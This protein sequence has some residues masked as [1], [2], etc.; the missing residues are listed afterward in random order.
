MKKRIA[1]ILLG[2][3]LIGQSFM[4]TG[5][6]DEDSSAA[7]ESSTESTESRSADS[8]SQP[9]NSSESDSSKGDARPKLSLEEKIK[10]Y[11]INSKKFDLRNVNGI[12]YVTPVRSQAPFGTCW[13]FATVAAIESS[14]LGAGLNG[15]DGKPA[16]PKTLDLSEKQIAWFSA[17]ALNDPENSQNGE[18]QYVADFMNNVSVLTEFMNRG[19]N[20]IFST[21][22]LAQGIGP[23][24]ES[25]DPNLE[26]H[27]KDKVIDYRGIGDSIKPLAYSAFDDWT[28][29][30]ECRFISSYSVKETH[31]LPSPSER[32]DDG[33]YK[34][35]AEAT[36][37]IKEELLALRGVQISFMA[38][39]SMPD[40]NNSNT[41]FI[42]NNWAHYTYLPTGTNHAVTIVGWDDDYSKEN[43]IKGTE[44]VEMIDGSKKTFDKTPPENGAWLV[45]NS[46]GSGENDF[47]DNNGGEWGIEENGKHTG[48]FWLSYYDQSLLYP[49]S[50][51]VEE[52]DASVDCT[53][54]YD[55]LPTGM[56]DAGRFKDEHKM[57]N[58]FYL[59]HNETLRQVSFFTAEPDTEV[60]YEI[61]LM[62]SFS[63]NPVKG[64]KV[65]EKTFSY[66]YIGFH[67]ENISDFDILVDL[68]GNGSK[69]LMMTRFQSY[70]VVVTQKAKDGSYLVNVPC[71]NYSEGGGLTSFKGIINKSE[72]YLF[73]DGEW[74]DYKDQDD[75]RKEILDGIYGDLQSYDY[76]NLNFDNFQIKTYCETAD[77]DCVFDLKGTDSLYY[78]TESRGSTELRLAIHSADNSP[79]SLSESDFIWTVGEEAG[80]YYETEKGERFGSLKV[81][82]KNADEVTAQIYVTVKNI[83][84][85]PIL[86]RTYKI[87][88]QNIVFP[89]TADGEDIQMTYAYTGKE[90]KPRITIDAQIQQ[91]VEDV[92]FKLKFENNIKCGVATITA[93]GLGEVVPEDNEVSGT[94][95]IV[96]AKVEI[97]DVSR[98][99]SSMTVTVKDMNDSGLTGYR[100]QY[101]AKGTEE[102]Q[103]VTVKAPNTALTVSGLDAGKDYE[104]QASGYTDVTDAPGWY[105][106]PVN[107]GES[108]EVQTVKA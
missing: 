104:I 38:D 41:Q 98:N 103:E 4:L 87:Y 46:W 25:A 40:A 64:L 73:K 84:T 106:D 49:V 34:Y 62:N 91:L 108:S 51:V 90:V 33:Y 27:G 72:S 101:R 100:L 42:S 6:S 31:I 83:G 61:Y 55:Y 94:F 70:S 35:N 93:T 22:A 9:D 58:I 26:Y 48:Y 81:T 95:V 88:M 99:G 89:P 60:T 74:I 15:A 79:M 80:K 29:P 36:K 3:L 13:S 76:D 45:K 5:C 18:G 24:H 102:W 92:D 69:D 8:T 77:H 71:A 43:F 78:K 7:G 37:A 107:Y 44:E 2:I 30:D 16:D 86:L 39:T 28:V 20:A 1:A 47:P 105:G 66:K 65:A 85:Y 96:P 57:A 50:Y 10:G 32:D 75:F 14:I 52:K 82:A 68:S 11:D 97:T 23:A 63:D 17:R 67:K 21:Q 56:A 59:A 19:G 12:S 53:D 54:Q